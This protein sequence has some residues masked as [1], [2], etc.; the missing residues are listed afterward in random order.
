MDDLRSLSEATERNLLVAFFDLTRYARETRGY[1]THA[2]FVLMSDY[3]EWVG[4]RNRTG[5]RSD[6]QIHRR[7]GAGRFF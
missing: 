1:D 6:R 4:D 2:L 5:G 3:Y 7:C